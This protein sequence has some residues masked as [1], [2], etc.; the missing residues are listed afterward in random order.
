MV[1]RANGA[2]KNK[3][4]KLMGEL[5]QTW[6]KVLPLALF[7][8]RVTPHSVTKLSPAEIIY[9]KPLRTPWGA[10]ITHEGTL[11]LHA[12]ND[13]IITYVQRLT[14]ILS[15][16]HLQVKESQRPLPDADQCE[17]VQPGDYVLI[18]NWNRKKLGPRWNGPYQVLLTT[19]TAVKV[20]NH[21]RWIHLSDCKKIGHKDGT[22]DVR[23]T[24][25]SNHGRGNMD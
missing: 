14:H 2:L 9:G 15:A 17:I 5:G 7:E 6:I 20:E 13:E 12:L 23:S 18:R 11:D 21:P 1:E 19:P 3:I 24:D 4:T 22:S 16:L 8:M 10:S 25:D